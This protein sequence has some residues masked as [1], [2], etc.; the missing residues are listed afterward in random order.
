M[1]IGPLK[2]PERRP[3]HLARLTSLKDGCI[4]LGSSGKTNFSEK[5]KI[6]LFKFFE[7]H[8]GLMLNIITPLQKFSKGGTTISDV[9]RQRFYDLYDQEISG[10][11]LTQVEEVYTKKKEV[12]LFYRFFFKTFL[13][14]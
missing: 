3:L 13:R 12:S 9:I 6:C 10:D 11:A 7:S 1:F 14:T 8:Q 5:L 4:E 2:D